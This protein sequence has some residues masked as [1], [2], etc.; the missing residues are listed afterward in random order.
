MT[1][2]FSTPISAEIRHFHDD[3]LVFLA[4]TVTPMRLTHNEATLS[5]TAGAW[6]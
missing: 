6:G 3:N 5:H 2:T 1:N 4:Y